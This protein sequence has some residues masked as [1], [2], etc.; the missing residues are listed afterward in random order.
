MKHLTALAAGVA[1]AV[2]AGSASAWTQPTH[3]NIVK[4]AL[5]FMNSSYATADMKRAYQFYVSA[6]GSEAKAGDIL[7]Q[8]AEEQNDASLYFQNQ[9]MGQHFDHHLW[10][11]TAIARPI[12]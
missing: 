10:G 6:A 2:S 12:P 9:K 1:L 8:A 4:D 5:A 3:K 11:G 7:G